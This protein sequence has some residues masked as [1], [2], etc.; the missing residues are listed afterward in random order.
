[1]LNSEDRTWPLIG[2]QHLERKGK[3]E[4]WWVQIQVQVEAGE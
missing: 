3:M 1:M 4:E 2:A